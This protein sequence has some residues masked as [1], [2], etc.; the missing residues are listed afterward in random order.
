MIG[1]TGRSSLKV[2]GEGGSAS[3]REAE[4]LGLIVT[5]LVM[6][7]LK[8]AFPGDKAKGQITVAYDRAGTDWKLSISDNG[9]GKSDG[10]LALTKNPDWAPASSK[11]F[12]INSMPRWKP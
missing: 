1:D 8:H 9:V 3:S 5:E 6:N 10:V 11:R 12:Q 7:A 4:S 2:V